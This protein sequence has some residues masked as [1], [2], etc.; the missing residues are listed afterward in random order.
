VDA[1]DGNESRHATAERVGDHLLVVARLRI[2]CGVLEDLMRPVP[3]VAFAEE[4]KVTGRSL[5]A[6]VTSA[7][8]VQIADR[9]TT[10]E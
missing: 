7:K 8:G 1:R 10:I 9:T 6:A 5:F 3:F 4:E 2:F